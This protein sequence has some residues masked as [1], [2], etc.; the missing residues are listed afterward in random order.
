MRGGKK[1]VI[2]LKKKLLK[3]LITIRRLEQFFMQRLINVTQ[4]A[5]KGNMRYLVWQVYCDLIFQF[6]IFSMSIYIFLN[7][8]LQIG[9]D[10]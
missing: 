6:V 1:D 2:T 10:R 4:D 5:T 9:S 8:D 3:L 7:V